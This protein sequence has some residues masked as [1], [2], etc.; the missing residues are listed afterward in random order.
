MSLSYII[1][2]NTFIQPFSHL[3]L[4]NKKKLGNNQIFKIH[5]VAPEMLSR[6]R[7]TGRKT[8]IP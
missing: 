2:K 1:Y 5:Y 8:I 3:L 4:R 6:D 7:N